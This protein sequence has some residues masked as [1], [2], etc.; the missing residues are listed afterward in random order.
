MS[1][2]GEKPG[3]SHQKNKK[4]EE[5]PAQATGGA[6]LGEKKKDP[7]NPGR[8]K[9]RAIKTATKNRFSKKGG[10]FSEKK[11]ARHRH[12]KGRISTFPNL[13]TTSGAKGWGRGSS[14][15]Q[16]HSRGGGL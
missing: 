16:A 7:R 14:R 5:S 8:K 15:G 1:Q 12:R 3:F 6:T 13:Y 11:L 9:L 10:A 2:G 4:K